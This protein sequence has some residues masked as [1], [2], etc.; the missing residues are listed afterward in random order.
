MMIVI[1]RFFLGEEKITVNPPGNLLRAAVFPHDPFWLMIRSKIVILQV[2]HWCLRCQGAP[3]GP[4]GGLRGAESRPQLVIL[5]VFHWQYPRNYGVLMAK[6]T[7]AL[8]KKNSYI[9]QF[10]SIL[11][12]LT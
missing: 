7:A 4:Q 12:D 3:G 2:R 11:N 1:V 5:A 8:H 6:K 10:M 9:V